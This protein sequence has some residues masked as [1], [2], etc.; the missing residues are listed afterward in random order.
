MFNSF[1]PLIK[2]KAVSAFSSDAIG[3]PEQRVR[4][5]SH[6]GVKQQ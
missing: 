6:R 5:A 3:N 1:A 4:K 2:F